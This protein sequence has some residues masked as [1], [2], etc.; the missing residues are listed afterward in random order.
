MA[1]EDRTMANG[2]GGSFISG[3][4]IGGLVGAIVGIMLAPKSGSETR[5]ELIEQSEALRLRGEE[6]AARVRER[7]GPA[8]DSVRDRVQPVT[9]QMTR[10]GRSSAEDAGEGETVS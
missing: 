7:V 1:K 2:N 3:F 10:S 5:A 8:V 9:S 6:L 4:L